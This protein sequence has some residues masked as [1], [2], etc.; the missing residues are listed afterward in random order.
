MAEVEGDREIVGQRERERL[1][2]ISFSAKLS[3]LKLNKAATKQLAEL[4][5]RAKQTPQT[6][7]M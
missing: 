2:I 3:L 7:E 5:K 1:L 6:L 4:A